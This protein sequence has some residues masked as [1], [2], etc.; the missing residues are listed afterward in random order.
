MSI[1]LQKE[2]EAN[3]KETI[4]QTPLWYLEEKD[5]SWLKDSD[6]TTLK[7][8]LHLPYTSFGIGKVIEL[9]IYPQATAAYRTQLNGR[10]K[11]DLVSY[12]DSDI[13]LAEQSGD[14]LYL[15]LK[16]ERSPSPEML[17]DHLK[18]FWQILVE[19]LGVEHLK[20]TLE[21][22]LPELQTWTDDLT[23]EKGL[24]IESL[25]N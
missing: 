11:E 19:C 24:E 3:R 4:F 12:I 5:Y 22:T 14:Y 20:Q 2:F 13:T 23:Y 18:T 6:I 25:T 8:I 9:S 17:E 16:E 21:I 10:A 7:R 1:V 15:M